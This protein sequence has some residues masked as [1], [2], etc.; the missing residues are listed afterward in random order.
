MHV[1]KNAAF[2]DFY[3]RLR[4]IIKL[5]RFDLK[6]FYLFLFIFNLRFE[7]FWVLMGRFEQDLGIYGQG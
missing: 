4:Y 5:L 7:L 3:F 1:D 2:I 6:L